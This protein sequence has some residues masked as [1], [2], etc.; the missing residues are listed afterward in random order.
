MA[1]QPNTIAAVAA[2]LVQAGWQR[3]DPD[4]RGLYRDLPGRDWWCCSTE[5]G[6]IDDDGP[7]QLIS[8][9]HRS[10]WVCTVAGDAEAG[11]LVEDLTIWIQ[12]EG[13]SHPCCLVTAGWWP[14][15]RAVVAM[16]HAMLTAMPEPY[17]AP[18]GE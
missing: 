13:Y 5:P 17:R 10:G 7:R 16:A 12:L 11:G 2:E 4:R 14:G 1:E 3:Q 9:H 8:L 18:A 15:L 6:L